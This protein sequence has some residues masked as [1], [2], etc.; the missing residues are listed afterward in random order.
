M[1]GRTAH[2]QSATALFAVKSDTPS[3][4]PAVATHPAPPPRS[5]PLDAL[6]GFA[7]LGII[8]VNSAYFAYPPLDPLPV[9][10]ASDAVVLWLTRT[11]GWG[12][13]FIIFSLLFGFGLSTMLARGAVPA[14]GA[15]EGGSPSVRGRWLRRALGLFALGLAHAV[16]LFFGDILMLYAVLSVGVWWLRRSPDRTLWRWAAIVWCVGLVSQTLV[17]QPPP[18][19]A[20]PDFGAQF[21]VSFDGD[22][23]STVRARLTFLPIA[24][25]VVAMFNGPVAFAAMLVGFA[26]GRSGRLP[27]SGESLEALRRPALAALAVGTL[28]SGLGAAGLHLGEDLRGAVPWLAAVALSAS[29]P[30]LSAGMAALTLRAFA[31]AETHPLVRALA[32][33]GRGSLTAYLLHSAALGFVFHGWGLGHFGTMSQAGVM[34]VAWSTFLLLAVAINLWHLRFRYGPD[35]WLLRSFMDLRWKPLLQPAPH[36]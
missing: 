8:W 34:A 25:I 5:A 23:A 31:R 1:I 27:P 18:A 11:F 14:A 10:S 16:G 12:K 22:Y 13:F 36:R 35:E 33:L 9:E 24:L 29:A 2:P 30:V 20:P 32:G 6:R 3:A 7:L 4:A 15:A 19:D 21:A 28:G 17:L 26:L